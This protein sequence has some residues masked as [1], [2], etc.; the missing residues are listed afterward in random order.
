MFK[1]SKNHIQI[2]FQY[3]IL[4]LTLSLP[5]I[6]KLKIMKFSQIV[7]APNKLKTIYYKSPDFITIEWTNA[8]N[9]RFKKT[10]WN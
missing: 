8:M 1:L 10:N 5:T 4:N 6:I 2:D 3:E 7:N 9:T